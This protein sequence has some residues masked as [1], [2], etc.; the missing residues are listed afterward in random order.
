M[1]NYFIKKIIYL[2]PVNKLIIISTL[3]LSK[4]IFVLEPKRHAF[5]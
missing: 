4:F 1:L 2:V 5:L 3:L